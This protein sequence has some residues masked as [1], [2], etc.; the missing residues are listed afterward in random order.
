MSVTEYRENIAAADR[1]LLAAINRRLELVRELHEH[2]RAEG[3]PLRDPTREEQLVVELQAANAG[4]LSSAGVA[5]LF[6][7][8]LDLTRKEIHGG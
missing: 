8:V 3:I 4:P 7:H 2:K 6:R 5:E 1:D